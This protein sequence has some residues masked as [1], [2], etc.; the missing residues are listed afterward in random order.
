[1][2]QQNWYDLE[3]KIYNS[4]NKQKSL[5]KY[6]YY[7]K[8]VCFGDFVKHFKTYPEDFSPEM[9]LDINVALVAK[10]NKIL[11]IEN[12]TTKVELNAEKKYYN[13][14]FELAVKGS[15]FQKNIND[16]SLH[17]YKGSSFCTNFENAIEFYSSKG[18]KNYI[19]ELKLLQENLLMFKGKD[20]YN[21]LSFEILFSNFNVDKQLQ[22]VA[23][24]N[25]LLSLDKY[26]L[27]LKENESYINL[28]QSFFKS[29]YDNVLKNSRNFKFTDN[30]SFQKDCYN[31]ESLKYLVNFSKGINA[32]SYLNNK[33][34]IDKILALNPT[35][36][37]VLASYMD[38]IKKSKVGDFFKEENYK[39]ISVTIDFAEVEKI[40]LLDDVKVK[41]VNISH[42]FL[43]LI[44]K[45]KSGNN[46]FSWFFR[47]DCISVSLTSNVS[48]FLFKVPKNQIK[49]FGE[50]F[51]KS[52]IKKQ[53]LNFVNEYPNK[54]MEN[55][56]NVLWQEAIIKKDI[57]EKISPVK[58]KT[59]VNK[60]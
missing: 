30:L 8:K 29:Y 18:K 60:F 27:F 42:Q 21:E 53:F 56:Y 46:P 23:L 57:E 19:T 52:F 47:D 43:L 33:S 36:K 5:M 16:K 17:I 45:E 28:K 14:L 7:E 51:V 15:N 12:L 54:F 38:E 10:V 44:Q 59:K 6:G 2:S 48:S 22:T 31:E 11:T 24:K 4:L 39:I 58:S 9:V 25:F 40:L 55:K 13:D 35:A 37:E 34:A 1:M 20:W 49:E 3:N 26:F 32:Y 41:A 50:D